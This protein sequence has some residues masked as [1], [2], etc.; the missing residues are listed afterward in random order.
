MILQSIAFILIKLKPTI[1]SY[2]MQYIREEIK[3]Q[4]III[5]IIIL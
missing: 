4:Q 5:L 1:T 3:V 2:M